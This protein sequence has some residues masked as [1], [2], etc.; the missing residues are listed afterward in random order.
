MLFIISYPIKRKGNKKG[1]FM[2]NFAKFLGIIILTVVIGFSMAACDDGSGGSDGGGDNE[3]V[4]LPQSSGT[5]EVVGKTLYLSDWKKI[6]FANSGTSFGVYEGDWDWDY[7]SDECDFILNGKGSYSYNSGNKTITLAIEQIYEG[8][9][10]GYSFVI[11]G[12][13]EKKWMNKTQV[14]NESGKYFDALI[15]R[16]RSN[17]DDVILWEAAQEL[18]IWDDY[19]DDYHDAGYPDDNTFLKQWLTQKGYNSISLISQW[20]SNNSSMNTPDKYINVGLASQGYKNLAEAKAGFVSLLLD[21]MFPLITYEYQFT[22]DNALLVQEK[23]PANKGSNE[24]RGKSFTHTKDE[25]SY[26][27]APNGTYT[28]ESDWFSQNGTYA[29]NSNTKEVWLKPEKIDG[30]TMLEYYSSS[31]EDNP[32]NKAMDTNRTFR[33][34]R[35]N[36]GLD[37]N[38]IGWKHDYDYEDEDYEDYSVRL[39]RS[40]AN[41]TVIKNSGF[42]LFK[43]LNQ[44]NRQP[45]AKK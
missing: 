23:L 39:S 29:Y 19:W 42:K 2:K 28:A 7:D 30:E 15:A 8:L 35:Y 26:T 18:P 20:K 24:L 36:Y 5:N 14:K 6:V 40:I 33:I 22:T 32:D 9:F 3:G 13:G 43:Q 4:S 37:P 31:W 11:L 16:I 21:E 17:F 38:W 25:I 1:V 41:T 44:N 27:F 45:S 12:Y 34:D 10:F